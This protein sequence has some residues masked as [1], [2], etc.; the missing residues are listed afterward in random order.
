LAVSVVTFR[1]RASAFPA[2]A[3][4]GV[5]ILVDDFAPQPMAG[6]VFWSNNRLGGE[7]RP[8]GDKAPS[9]AHPKPSVVRW[10]KGFVRVVL[11]STAHEGG[12]WTSLNHPLSDCEPLDFSALFP[13]QI[14][15]RYQGRISGVRIHI[16][17]GR[18]RFQLA[19]LRGSK[20]SCSSPQANRR[21]GPWSVDL[22][23]GARTL[24]FRVSKETGEV[25]NLNWTLTGGPGSFVVVDRVELT[26]ALPRLT[27]AKRAF[28]WNYAQLL[29][30]WNP[31]SG[32]TRDQAQFTANEN[33]NVSAS[34]AQA[35][36]AVIAYHGGFISRTSAIGIVNKTTEALMALPR[37]GR[38]CGGTNLWPHF[39]KGR[40]IFP[41]TEWSSIDTVIAAVSLIEARQSLRLPTARVER[42]LENINWAGLMLD[43]KIGHGFWDKPGGC[44][45]INATWHDFGLESWIVNLGYA[46]A[47]GETTEFENAPPS[48]SGG[49]FIDELAWLLFPEP[50][51]DR[52]GIAWRAYSQKAVERQLSYYQC[53]K[54]RKT[55]C[56]GSG[57][58]C[59]AQNT[60]SDCRCCR[61][62]T[63]FGRYGLFGLTPAEPPDLS[64][65]LDETLARYIPF[66][67]CGR[68]TC[69]DGV[70]QLGHPVVVPH[71]AGIVAALRPAQAIAE[72]K[73]LESKGL[74]TPLNSAESLMF[75][76][77]PSCKQIVWNA[78]RGAWE[79]AL[80][81]LGWG[82]Y[83]TG[84]SNPLY[85]AV[86]NNAF[87]MGGY[88]VMTRE[89]VP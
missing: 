71:Y 85:R 6:Q 9:S 10:G 88:E 16:R 50:T 40:R 57:D 37:D 52:F 66:G 21:P 33:N 7:R 68:Y 47:T 76:D 54:A 69:Y 83:L 78:R 34:G 55:G 45:R 72:W 25:T 58:S 1:A 74:E 30:S 70:E 39:V 62:E 79:L 48:A 5:T 17:D 8:I 87:L 41:G 75:T 44:E 61:S 13:A 14:K 19:L 80:S 31:S 67:S 84:K 3:R 81:T 27:A 77:S 64:I 86:R 53:A 35:A 82:R 32:L 63:C 26:A 59:E 4:Q 43:G 23:G 89:V 24:F 15:A 12:V 56:C 11:S 18:G 28:L 60:G 49:G 65:A 22:N 51:L 42:I 38:S 36:A 2:S 46:A 20:P 73:W 29:S